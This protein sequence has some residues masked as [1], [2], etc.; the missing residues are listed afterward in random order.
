VSECS[1]IEIETKKVSKWQIV[2][3]R[4]Y[5]ESGFHIWNVSLEEYLNK[6]LYTSEYGRPVEQI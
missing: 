3:F 5:A 6:Y 2:E 4:N 1:I